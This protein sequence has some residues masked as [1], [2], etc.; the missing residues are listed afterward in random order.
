M[1]STLHENAQRTHNKI[2]LIEVLALE[3]EAITIGHLLTH[4][5]GLPDMLP[6]NVDLRRRH[7]PLADFVAQAGIGQ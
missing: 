1:L 7:A 6:E 4:T 3:I 5:S 2:R